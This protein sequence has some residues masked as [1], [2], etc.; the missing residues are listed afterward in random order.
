MPPTT[1]EAPHRPS[2][3]T[4][5]PDSSGRRRLA[6]AR[7]SRPR[8]PHAARHSSSTSSCLRPLAASILAAVAAAIAK[9]KDDEERHGDTKHSPQRYGALRPSP[10]PRGPL[11]VPDTAVIPPLDAALHAELRRDYLTPQQAPAALTGR[12]PRRTMTPSLPRLAEGL[13]GA[14]FSPCPLAAAGAALPLR[15]SPPA[16]DSGERPDPIRSLAA[17]RVVKRPRATPA[18]PYPPREQRA[19]PARHSPGVPSQRERRLRRI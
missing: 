15:K 16:R 6:S 9:A 2:A 12:T 5:S 18:T 14:R 19:S 1:T 10:A 11:Y 4:I 17:Q 13:C 3:Q 8:T 7:S